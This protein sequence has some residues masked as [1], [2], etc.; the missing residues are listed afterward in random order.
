MKKVVY[1][2]LTGN[3]DEL[4]QPLATRPD[5]DFVCF[6]DCLL[7]GQAGAWQVR[8]IPCRTKNAVLASRYA[9]LLPHKALPEYDW[10]L[11]IDANLQIVSDALFDI[12]DSHIAAGESLCQVAHWERDCA[13][14]ELVECYR[15]G[16]SSLCNARR[17]KKHLQKE[18]FPR[19]YGLYENNIILRRHN[20]EAIVAANEI[21]WKLFKKGPRRDQLSLTYIYWKLGLKPA[22]LLGEDENA[23]NSSHLQYFTHPAPDNKQGWFGRKWKGT[24]EKIRNYYSKKI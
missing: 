20:E 24:M 5:W 6:S 22:L 1:T 21:W 19:N 12:L 13:Y 14:D 9:K 17:F 7:E 15:L 8:R 10:S 11:Y 16:Y 2:C 23:R 3:Y 18:G 4:K